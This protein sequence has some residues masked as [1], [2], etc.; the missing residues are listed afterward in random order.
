MFASLCF[1]QIQVA[2][3]AWRGNG[4]PINYGIL[5]C[6][7][8][9]DVGKIYY[10]QN[11]E[12]ETGMA[13]WECQNIGFGLF[14]WKHDDASGASVSIGGSNGQILYNNS[15]AIGGAP[16]T[17]SGNNISGVGNFSI[18][19]TFTQSSTSALNNIMNI[20]HVTLRS[21]Y[22]RF[23]VS[24]TDQWVFGM[25]LPSAGS[26]N[27]TIARY[28]SGSYSEAG[29]TLDYS[30]GNAVFAKILTSDNFKRGT[31]SPES[32]VVGSV[33]DIYIRSD[34]A[35]G[36]IV[37]LKETGTASNTGWVALPSLSTIATASNT[38]TF[39]N[40]SISASQVNSGVLDIARLGTGGVGAGAKI[41]FDNGT[42][43]DVP[44][45]GAGT[46]IATISDL[47]PTRS[48][49]T[50][51][52][53]TLNIAAGRCK[54]VTK[55]AA[56]AKI[57]AG[58]GTGTYVAYCTVTGEVVVEDSSAAG[59]TITCTNCTRTQVTTPT[60]IYGQIPIASG[61]ISSGASVA[62]WSDPTDTRDLH[63]G[64][65]LHS[66]GNGMNVQCAS[67]EC[68]HQVDSAVV[69]VKTDPVTP[70]GVVSM[71][72]ATSVRP[73]KEGTSD[74]GSCTAGEVLFR[75]DTGDIKKCYSSAWVTVGS[76]TAPSITDNLWVPF[77]TG[78]TD[79]A[80]APGANVQRAYKI[81]STINRTFSKIRY[82]TSGTGYVAFAFVTSDGNTIITNGTMR[83]NNN[84][85]GTD[86]G[87][88]CAF[89]GNVSVPAG[90]SYYLVVTADASTGLHVDNGQFGV[91]GW[92]GG[93]GLG[94]YVGT[95]ANNSTGSGA[96]LAVS[97]PLGTI[98]PH[99]ATIAGN[100]QPVV[101]F[102]P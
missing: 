61:T 21:T 95:A 39:T 26:N 75:T 33:S 14:G 52:N 8:V 60:V 91:I 55:S 78:G 49:V 46:F 99:T 24:G 12:S 57:T 35:A 93:T 27:F 31:G 62:Q 87:M 69:Q 83:C 81:T 2:H 71:A 16:W 10:Q 85:V 4:E 68:I 5:V 92:L 19:Q 89:P 7:S 15:G 100:H 41:L 80:Y 3:R 43:G 18:G 34:G 53:D 37:Y 59:L 25:G 76:G 54:G 58:N 42:W 38:M 77:G 20:D 72:A 17:I 9:R 22:H 29:M 48:T 67:G 28:L 97:V 51:T 1:G 45:A 82:R 86:N 11:Y 94:T 79:N 23:Q 6:S 36:T 84:T 70:T 65:T 98:S 90:T 40:K 88:E 73:F 50:N 32:A 56:T 44:A 101:V 30:T 47:K 102:V 66:N 96:T 63:S 64:G 13:R 74:P